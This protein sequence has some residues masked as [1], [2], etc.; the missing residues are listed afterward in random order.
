MM[1]YDDENR[2]QSLVLL[3]DETRQYLNPRE[4]IAYREFRLELAEWL[5]NLGNTGV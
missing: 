3:A 1:S 4:E 2:Y 5:L